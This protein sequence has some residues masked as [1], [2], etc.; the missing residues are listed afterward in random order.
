MEYTETWSIRGQDGIFF[1]FITIHGL[2]QSTGSPFSDDEPEPKWLPSE[3]VDNTGCRVMAATYKNL[4]SEGKIHTRAGLQT[5][6]LNLLDLALQHRNKEEE[7][8]RPL[9]FIAHDFGGILLKNA[10]F[11]AAQNQEKY[12]DLLRQTY[13]LIFIACPHRVY[14]RNS[15]MDRIVDWMQDKKTSDS[16]GLVATA[17]S[18][19]RNTIHINGL[20]LECGLLQRAR[21]VSIFSEHPDASERIFPP[22]VA[23]LGIPTE[24]RLSSRQP[25]ATLLFSKGNDFIISEIKS[26][27]IERST[28][29]TQDLKA[30]RMGL[31]K[32][33]S[34]CPP[35]YPRQYDPAEK[36]FEWLSSKKDFI[37]WLGGSKPR[38]LH[39]VQCDPEDPPIEGFLRQLT[40]LRA[41]SG[42]ASLKYVHTFCYEFRKHDTRF[43]TI[44]SL[45]VS[46][47]ASAFANTKVEMGGNIS[48]ELADGSKA[49]ALLGLD[50][51]YFIDRLIRYFQASGK[52]VQWV[53]WNADTYSGSLSNLVESLMKLDFFT[54]C[55][56][57]IILQSSGSESVAE[58]LEKHSPLTISNE[59][60]GSP[61]KY[62]LLCEGERQQLMNNFHGLSRFSDSLSEVFKRHKQNSRLDVVFSSWICHYTK[63]IA[64]SFPA[65]Q[66]AS[67]LHD[68]S[69]IT[70]QELVVRMVESIPRHRCDWIRR[71]LAW[72]KNTFR[73]LT[74]WELKQGAEFNDITSDSPDVWPDISLELQE[75][76]L[77][78]LTVANNEVLFSHPSV[79]TFLDTSEYRS[80]I[81]YITDTDAHLDILQAS[82]RTL[83]RA[84]PF[85]LPPAVSTNRDV[86]SHPIPSRQD[87]RSYA[88]GY[89][90]RHY[91]MA[92]QV[93]Q[94]QH[95]YT[96]LIRSFLDNFPASQSWAS[97]T[98]IDVLSPGLA[99]HPEVPTSYRV[100]SCLAARNEL[101]TTD[102]DYLCP[103]WSTH[104]DLV[105]AAVSGA[106]IEGSIKLI[107][108]ITIPHED[109]AVSEPVIEAG[110]VCP[111]LE[112][113][114]EVLR[115]FPDIS[116]FP[117]SFLKRGI[118]LASEIIA[119]RIINGTASSSEDKQQSEILRDLLADAIHRRHSAVARLF[120]QACDSKDLDAGIIKKA[121]DVGDPPIIEML[122]KR[123]FVEDVPHDKMFQRED[124]KDSFSSACS[125]GNAG[126]LRVLLKHCAS[127][128]TEN[129]DYLWTSLNA[130][131]YAGF[132]DC[133]DQLLELIDSSN[134]LSSSDHDHLWEA[135]SIGVG[136][137]QLDTCRVLLM[138]G[139]DPNRQKTSG[140]PLLHYAFENG[141]TPM[142]GLLLG[143]GAYLEAKDN[144]GRTALHAAVKENRI[145]FVKLLLRHGAN[146]NPQISYGGTPLYEACLA[147]NP[148]MVD[149]LLCESADTRISTPESNWSPL[150]VA[151]DYPDILELLV[152]KSPDFKRIANGATALWRAARG[153]HDK[154]VEM[155]LRGDPDIDFAPTDYSIERDNGYT[156][157]AIA[158]TR[159]HSKVARLL[160][161]A[162][163]NVDFVTPMG[164]PIL[165]LAK[166]DETLTALLE[167]NPN[168]TLVDK[169]RNTALHTLMEGSTPDFRGY[170]RLVNSGAKVNEWNMDGDTPL[171]IAVAKNDIKAVRYL[172]SK[173]A[174]VNYQVD[175]RR[176]G[177]PLHQAC[178]FADLE[179]VKFLVAKGAEVGQVHSR[180]GSGLYCVCSSGVD[181][182]EKL[183]YL[184]EQCDVK[185]DQAGGYHGHALNAAC[186]R[187]D[188]ESIQYLVDRCDK[189]LLT[190]PDEAGRPPVFYAAMRSEEPRE[191]VKYLISKGVKVSSNAIDAMGRTLLHCA[192]QAHNPELVELI[193]AQNKD[194]IHIQDKDGWT[195]LHWAARRVSI[196]KPNDDGWWISSPPT[197]N[198]KEVIRLLLQDGRQDTSLT[199]EMVDE[200]W[201][202]IKLARFHGLDSTIQELLQ[203]E[204]QSDVQDALDSM[205]GKA[206][207]RYCDLCFA[208]SVPFPVLLSLTRASAH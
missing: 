94:E 173:G 9:A 135:L 178:R 98:G 115:L 174:D 136:S 61:S 157:L 20:F 37:E 28:F 8:E 192:A 183:R 16:C 57:Q 70:T 62:D 180:F 1:D 155:L 134:G 23:T 206:Y 207:Y 114:H 78:L 104:S 131:V 130:A 125:Y 191:I 38:L 101:S 205:V 17:D 95:M 139:V 56:F 51:P 2:F 84:E 44:R 168:L 170:K 43:V 113:F 81:W 15:F 30:A 92:S 142:L 147:N 80:R 74:I 159:R 189:S 198:V 179:M 10:L 197:E 119:E 32:Q 172:I 208:V 48:R 107:R 24:Y 109:E 100:V 204:S 47:I 36:G 181:Q 182:A 164:E 77:G 158:V 120:I 75:Y 64:T 99:D 149:V 169:D 79:R 58:Q 137:G 132:V 49:E 175:G 110:A 21:T 7:K 199:I 82:L 68:L 41:S 91:K 22:T 193:I 188:M 45:L 76:S 55:P 153:G 60:S 46:F 93:V 111:D 187:S 148:D 27:L 73:P 117:M 129:K 31:H 40:S 144:S 90:L 106:V 151:F 195:P 160:L 5:A 3:L 154:S 87:F 150:E 118:R 33:M 116:K 52:S 71:V 128:E 53:I 186:L 156:S 194:M 88:A 126:A 121:C 50:L 96:E 4:I 161:E 103:R 66:V 138:K 108:E 167:Y 18:W 190:R 59:E 35:V 184:V 86:T 6:A 165:H 141:K 72:V 112:T 105:V 152:K 25:L 29:E 13:A 133:T 69:T 166:D 54:E 163:A 127:S 124:L 83:S 185:I 177:G 89:W 11:I 201:T 162:G 122:L 176:A 202:P 171:T 67:E 63:V 145:S 42:P 146:I 123:G 140:V 85:I 102:L 19:C 65:T 200:R 14:D 143:Y 97:M 203:P 39:L 196:P 12:G 26:T 34:L